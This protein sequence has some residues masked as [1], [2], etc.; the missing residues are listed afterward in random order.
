MYYKNKTVII[1]KE[2]N[3][4]KIQVSWETNQSGFLVG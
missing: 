1:G 2:M 3:V 4:K